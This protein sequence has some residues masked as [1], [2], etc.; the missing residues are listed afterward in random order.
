MEKPGSTASLKTRKKVKLPLKS[1]N[2]KVKFPRKI[3]SQRPRK[4]RTT[5]SP[6]KKVFNVLGKISKAVSTKYGTPI[7][8]MP[9]PIR[10]RT[11][12][13]PLQGSNQGKTQVKRRRR[14]RRVPFKR[15]FSIPGKR[16]KVYVSSKDLFHGINF[17]YRGKN[18]K[19]SLRQIRQLLK[20]KKLTG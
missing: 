9:K 18:Y 14:R 12:R 10:P 13:R 4:R 5:R 2:T 11:T 1:T 20:R 16:S 19:L 6:I 15:T 7:I 3:V 17:N 8:S